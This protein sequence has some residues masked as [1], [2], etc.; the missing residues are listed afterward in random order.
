MAIAA[1]TLSLGATGAIAA[2][3]NLYEVDWTAGTGDYTT[4]ANWTAF[5]GGYTRPYNRNATDLGN[6]IDNP[7][8]VIGNGGTATIDNSSPLPLEGASEPGFP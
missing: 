1:A 4:A 5:N 8:L 7:F 6:S 3:P 2:T